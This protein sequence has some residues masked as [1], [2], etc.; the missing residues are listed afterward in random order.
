[1]SSLSIVRFHQQMIEL[2]KESITDVD[3]NERDVSAIQVPANEA[4]LKKIKNEV[5]AFRKHIVAL[6]ENENECE[7]IL[8][9]NIQLFPVTEH[10]RK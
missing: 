8:Q 6:C 3:E 4:L 2:A 7:R 1:M 9:L 10:R 5:R